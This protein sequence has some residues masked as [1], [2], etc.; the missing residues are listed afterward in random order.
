MAAAEPNP[1]LVKRLFAEHRSALRTFFLR[2]IWTKVDAPDDDFQS[3][4]GANAPGCYL[5]LN[6]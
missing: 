2:R 3:R 1:S 4:W 6:L 5:R